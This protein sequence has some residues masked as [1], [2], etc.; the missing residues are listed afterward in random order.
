MMRLDR[1]IR[2]V[3]GSPEMSDEM[4][5]RL[6]FPLMLKYPFDLFKQDNQVDFSLTDNE[7][8]RV[9]VNMFRQMGNIAM[10]MRVISHTIPEPGELRL[11]EQVSNI[12]KMRQGWLFFPVL[13]V[14]VNQPPWCHC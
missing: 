7:G 10:V 1:C 5:E 12:T 3:K 13:P 2:Q 9:R 11:P 8:N 6:L 14:Q 4:I